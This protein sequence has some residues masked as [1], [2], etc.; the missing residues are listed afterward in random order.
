MEALRA[1]PPSGPAEDGT[2]EDT[3]QGSDELETEIGH[4]QAY[5]AQLRKFESDGSHTKEVAERLAA[6]KARKAQTKPLPA[7]QAQS[8]QRIARRRKVR[9]RAKEELDAAQAHAEK[10]STDLS[11]LDTE[12][13]LLEEESKEL[14]RLALGEEHASAD[15][16]LKSI[17][18]QVPPEL[19][20]LPAGQ[21]F[22]EQLRGGLAQL[23]AELAKVKAEA[24][25][26]S[27]GVQG[28][29]EASQAAPAPT[30]PTQASGR[31]SEAGHQLW[32]DMELDDDDAESVAKEILG[33]PGA[34]ESEEKYKA[35]LQTLAKSTKQAVGKRLR[36]G[37]NPQPGRAPAK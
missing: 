14:N 7:R 26:S 29:A 11:A 24:T 37:L 16:I 5:L 17:A 22:M 32:A 1:S 13:A 21:G 8:A 33:G 10:L 9:E 20:V 35:R 36:K 6:A 18:A 15:S 34:G 30:Q 25:A 12:L 28:M 19:S 31:S 2:A 23:F 3:K 27:P 4:L